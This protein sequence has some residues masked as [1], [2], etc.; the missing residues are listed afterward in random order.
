MDKNVLYIITVKKIS[1]NT[2]IGK[3]EYSYITILDGVNYFAKNLDFTYYY[4][5]VSIEIK[6]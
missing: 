5:I 2:T 3:L 6:K 1:D 4:F